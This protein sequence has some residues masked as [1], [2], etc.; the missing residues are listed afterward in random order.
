MK[1]KRNIK[2]NNTTKKINKR[3]IAWFIVALF[4]GVQV[5]FAVQSATSGA[6]LAELEYEEEELIKGNQEISQYIVES[7]SLS[8]MEETADELGFRKPD[9]TYYLTLEELVAQLP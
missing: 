6:R 7:S 3:N 8:E 2:S 5:L 1:F 9:T 4:V